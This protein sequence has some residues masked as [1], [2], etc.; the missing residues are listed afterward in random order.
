MVCRQDFT[1]VV[2]IVMRAVFHKAVALVFFHTP[3]A[4]VACLGL[5]QTLG[6]AEAKGVRADR[7]CGTRACS[8]SQSGCA[9]FF[10]YTVCTS[11]MPWS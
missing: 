10:S 4:R 1:H 7:S 8:F 5:R 2:S 3:S 9:G 6:R 11:G